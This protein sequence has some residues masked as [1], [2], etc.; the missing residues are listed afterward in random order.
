MPLRCVYTD[1]DGTLLGRGASL[2]HDGEGLV[3]MAGAKAIQACLRADVEVCIYSGRNE[4][5]VKEDA[6]LFGQTAYIFEVG[7]GVVIDGEVEYLTGDLQPTPDFSIFE[8]ID[9]SGA[10]QLLLEAYPGRLE[11]HAPWH[12][13]RKISHLFR[14]AV[15]VNAANSLL[16][17]EGLGYLRLVDNGRLR[18]PSHVPGVDHLSAYH[19]IPRVAGKGAAV[20]RHMQIRG[21]R[22]DE[23][24]AV[25]DSAE[26]LEVARVVGHFFLMRNAVEQNPELEAAVQ[27]HSN[28][29]VTEAAN[30][31]GVYEA[32]VGT[33]ATGGE[34]K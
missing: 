12:I 20:S 5:Q 3:T 26:D 7:C 22:P 2:F 24:I 10:P 21:Y 1:L 33:L 28:V 19:L 27:A 16:D 34:I 25:G 8:Q 31:A 9:R 18:R 17:S 6:R 32:V 13:N 11:H 4:V 23:C 15:D 29:T 30:G 14:G